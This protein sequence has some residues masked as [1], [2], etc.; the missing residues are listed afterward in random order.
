MMYWV[1]NQAQLE[2]A[3]EAWGKR[4]DETAPPAGT[5]MQFETPSA[6][7]KV[8]IRAFLDS[9]EARAAKLMGGFSYPGTGETKAD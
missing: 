8:A 7:F 1:F 2:E 5:V 9:D 6:P 4:T 3:L